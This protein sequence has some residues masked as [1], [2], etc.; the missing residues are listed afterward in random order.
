MNL[1]LDLLPLA[2]V[3]LISLGLAVGLICLVVGVHCIDRAGLDSLHGGLCAQLA[4]RVVGLH[5]I[6]LRDES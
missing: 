3:G 4:R 5:A 2:I 1:F 6:G